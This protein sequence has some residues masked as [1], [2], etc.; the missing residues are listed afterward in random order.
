VAGRKPVGPALAERVWSA[1]EPARTRLK[2]LLET[3]TGDKTMEQACRALSIQKTQLF[4]LRTRVL[5]AAAAALE[6]QPIGRPPQAVSPE[7]ARI[8]EL[9]EEINQLTVELEAS[10]VRVELAQALP[11]AG[12]EPAPRRKKKRRR[13]R[14]A[15][16]GEPR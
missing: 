1:S 11:A 6:P 13:G 8:T 10:R 4:K 9:E 7:A 3:I 16:S 15:G 14:R 2:V 12:G 5:E